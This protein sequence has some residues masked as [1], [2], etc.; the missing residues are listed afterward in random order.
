MGET[1]SGAWRAIPVHVGDFDPDYYMSVRRVLRI[2]THSYIIASVRQRKA[3][4]SHASQVLAIFV[5]AMAKQKYTHPAP[6]YVQKTQHSESSSSSDDSESDNPEPSKRVAKVSN[7][8]STVTKVPQKLEGSS[9]QTSGNEGEGNS[10]DS[11]KGS[12]G[13][14]EDSSS[15]SE[16]DSDDAKPRKRIVEVP[17]KGSKLKRSRRDDDSPAENTRP[18]KRVTK[19]SEQYIFHESYNESNE[20][21]T[22]LAG[23][24][25]F[26]VFG[27][28]SFD[29]SQSSEYKEFNTD[30]PNSSHTTI[31]IFSGEFGR[32]PHQSV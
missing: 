8:K 7:K 14:D 29:I 3:S 22:I 5:L 15:E 11:S 20:A 16:S 9:S 19:E 4:A 31:Q 2:V 24:T 12:K 13:K 1:R 25:Y 27:L 30:P 10:S 28:R 6:K 32:A 18:S 26:K 21:C 23:K 17:V